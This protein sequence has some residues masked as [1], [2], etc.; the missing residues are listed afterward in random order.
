MKK[1][2]VSA[3]WDTSENLVERLIRQFKTPNINL[4]DIEFVS[5]DSYDII[6]FFNYVN[7]PIKINSKSYVFPNEPSWSGSHQKSFDSNTTVF[8]F[9][10]NLYNG[11]FI[12]SVSHT[13]YGGRGPWVDSLDFWSYENLKEFK[14]NKSKNISSSITRLKIDNGLTCLYPQRFIISKL[15]DKLPFIDFYGGGDCSPKRKD[16]LIDYRF[17]IAIEN[18]YS[19]NWITEKFYDSILTDTIPIYFGCKNIREIYPEDG[20]ILIDNI[21]DLTSIENLLINIE[22]NADKIYNEKIIG[23]R[24]IKERYFKEFNLLKKII[25]L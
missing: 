6:V 18:E 20:Y 3:N 15:I 9:K 25:D 10:Q 2:K 12:E 8:G 16:S 19:D 23:L 13:F 22:K 21:D 7:Q 11:N 4:S 17:N 5:D 1:I 14:F 24:K